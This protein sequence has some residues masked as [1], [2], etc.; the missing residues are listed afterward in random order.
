MIESF[1]IK[2]FLDSYRISFKDRGKNVSRGWLNLEVCPFCGDSSFHFGVNIQDLTWHCW[3]CDIKPSSI[4]NKEGQSN[5]S[6]YKLLREIDQFKGKHLSKIIQPFILGGT[7]THAR[8]LNPFAANPGQE[9]PGKLTLPQY[10]L[11]DLPLPHRNYLIKRGFDPDL[12]IKKFGLKAVYNIGD[13]KY[14]FRI[15][16]PVII[17]RKPVSFVAAA[18]I[19]K[20]G[21]IPYLNCTPEEAEIPINRCLYNYDSIK[22]TAVIVEGI[23]DVWR[24]GD[25]FVAT[26]RKGMTLEQIDLL[27]M[28]KP[29]RV[30]VMYD[31]DAI[32]QAKALA[33]KLCGLFPDVGIYELFEGDPG[34]LTVEEA[35][36]LRQEIFGS[37][38]N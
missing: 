13:D 38:R 4:E 7:N 10:L 35:I 9:K 15:I 33:E 22:D 3:V 27:R 2:N 5:W 19:R 30:L 31:S 34:G 32:N 36:E 16:A 37:H 24:M 28:K 6:F 8:P 1:D 18:T 25:G 12:L 20:D 26:F 23:S 14:R 21:I 29:K 11:D 17:N